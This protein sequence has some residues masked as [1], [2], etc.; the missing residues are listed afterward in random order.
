MKGDVFRL[1]RPR[2][3]QG[4][5]QQHERFAVVV[6][7]TRL[8]HLSTWVVAPTSTRARPFVFRPRVELP[9]GPTLVICDALVSIDPERRLGDYVASL[10]T[11]ET[12]EIDKTLTLFLDLTGFGA[13]TTG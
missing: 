8:L 10:T 1:R 7:A 9:F 4:R 12:L 3:A 11:D 2:D 13:G 5:E 6:Q